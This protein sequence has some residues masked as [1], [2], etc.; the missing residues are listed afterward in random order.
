MEMFLMRVIRGRYIEPGSA[1]S[2]REQ[3][4]YDLLNEGLTNLNIARMMDEQ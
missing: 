1:L 3:H 2:M 4:V